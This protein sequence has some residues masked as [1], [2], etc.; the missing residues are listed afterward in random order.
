MPI[1]ITREVSPEIGRCEL[2]FIERT[3]IDLDRA[4]RQHDAYCDLLGELG[5]QVSRIPA[6]PGCPD[7]CFVEDAAVVVDEAAVLTMMGAPSRRP[8]SRGVKEALGAR[9]TRVFT[10]EL[11]ATM[12]GGD[13]LVVDRRVF[14]GLTARTNEAGVGVLARCLAPFGYEV[15]G[16]ELSGC[17]HLKSA[18]TVLGPDR[19]LLNPRWL[20]PARLGGL[21]TLPVPEEE[22]WGANVLRIGGNVL[23][24]QGFGR[25]IRRLEAEGI[26]VV[27]L[28]VSEFLKAEAGLTCK[29]LIL[30]EEAP[31]KG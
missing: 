18:V 29:S 10:M 31:P 17:L 11:P 20:D 5:C 3:P 14:V 22:P 25:T 15:S 2:T 12:D 1:A 9:R 6:E 19:V 26:R 30:Q 24:H 13:V 27:P 16:V 28:D 7:S 23:V 8:E 21:A 4:R